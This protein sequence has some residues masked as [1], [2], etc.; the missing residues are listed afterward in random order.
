M[1][2]SKQ[3]VQ[4]QPLVERH[5]YTQMVG[6]Q[7]QPGSDL[8]LLVD[9]RD[10]AVPDPDSQGSTAIAAADATHEAVAAESDSGP[11]AAG[12]SVSAAGAQAGQSPC[13]VAS[14]VIKPQ[15]Q[16]QPTQVQLPTSPAPD[17]CHPVEKIP[18]VSADAVSASDSTPS[19]KIQPKA[20]HSDQHAADVRCVIPG[21]A[22]GGDVIPAACKSTSSTQPAAASQS[23][24]GN[25]AAK[26]LPK[27]CREA[28]ARLLAFAGYPA[29][30]PV[31]YAQQHK[32]HQQQAGSA[33][34]SSRLTAA[35]SKQTTACSDSCR[36]VA[37]ACWSPVAP[38]TQ[39]VKPVVVKQT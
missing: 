7:P 11:A 28:S 34:H 12:D 17:T 10:A 24:A 37:A 38:A 31:P 36:P 22:T 27:N 15:Q 2:T 39:M 25:P 30:T 14:T 20:Q 29:R 21:A 4:G 26:P 18:D 19:K 5:A 3:Q 1:Q 13:H 8:L 33:A 16:E 35:G 23:T 32:Q 9:N 6:N